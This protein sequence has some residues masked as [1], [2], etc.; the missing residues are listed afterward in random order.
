SGLTSA[1]RPDFNLVTRFVLGGGD[2]A[3]DQARVEF[4]LLLR[5]ITVSVGFFLVLAALGGGVEEIAAERRRET[6]TSL[7]GTPLTG[8]EILRAKLWATVWRLRY[9][10]G[11]L[12][13]L[14]TSGFLT[15]AIHPLGFVLSLLVIFSWT[16]FFCAW[17]MHGA[18]KAADATR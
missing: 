17:G 2:G 5:F 16:W 1:G 10:A 4:N 18:L 15:G 12:V 8:F 9:V 6:W 3:T 13:V 7:L 11:T 14:W